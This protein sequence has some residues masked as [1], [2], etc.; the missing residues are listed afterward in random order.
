MSGDAVVL[1]AHGSDA[2]DRVNSSVRAVADQIAATGTFEEVVAAFHCG[3]PHYSSVLDELGSA[4]VTVIPFMTCGGYYCDEVLPRELA[5][6][7]RFSQISVRI[8]PPVGTDPGMERIAADRVT[9]LAADH[10]IAL[11]QTTVLVVGHGTKRHAKSRD[12]TVALAGAL[13]QRLNVVESLPCFLDDEP[14]IDYARGVARGRNIIAIV[15]LLTDGPH[16]RRDVPAGLSL[17]PSSHD[18]PPY[19]GRVDGKLVVCDAPV[20]SDT[21]MARLVVDV[22]TK[23]SRHRTSRREEVA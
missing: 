3:V 5:R 20:G 9:A 14:T 1:A 6:N 19:V 15:F 8:T 13:A 12:A 2:D 10:N 23:A 4:R 21:A 17:H 11:A 18:E 7:T 16:A 22:A